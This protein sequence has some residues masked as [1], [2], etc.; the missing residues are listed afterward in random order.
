MR[1]LH[2]LRTLN[3]DIDNYLFPYPPRCRLYLLPRPISHFLGWRDPASPVRPT[4]NVTDWFWAFVGAFASIALVEA[5]VKA[6]P[7]INS[8][9]APLIVGSFGAAAI[10]QF[11]TP[12][13]PLAQPRPLVLGHLL[14]AASAIAITKLF[15]LSQH[16]LALRWLVGALSCATAS[17]IMGVT[18]TVHPPAGATA[19]LAAVDPGVRQ[20]GWWLMLHVAVGCAVML[21]LACLLMN[22]QKRWP[23]WWVLEGVERGSGGDAEMGPPWEDG[24]EEPQRMVTVTVTEKGTKLPEWVTLDR[25]ERAVLDALSERLRKTSG[26]NSG[27]YERGEESEGSQFSKEVTTLDGSARKWWRV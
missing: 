13:S 9:D 10:I 1:I 23:V 6:S 2:T 12:S 3:F 21:G 17:L 22:V 27:R 7:Q 4:G 11:H 25:E 18:K 20:L 16:F 14:S 8:H 19:L 5:I 24:A 15:A 26:V